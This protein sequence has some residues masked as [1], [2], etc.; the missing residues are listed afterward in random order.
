ML[1]ET[2]TAAP[3][4]AAQTRPATDI[5]RRMRPV[6][7]LFAACVGVFVLVPLLVIV[8]SSFNT[9]GFWQFPPTGVTLR[10]YR[11]LF[12]DPEFI[13]SFETSF[14]TAFAVTVMAAVLGV[15]AAVGITRGRKGPSNTLGTIALLPLLFP[16]VVLGVAILTLYLE[17]GARI[18]ILTLAL[19]QL[20]PA[21]PFAIRLMSVSLVG[22]SP[23]LERAAQNLGASPSRAFMRVVMPLTKGALLTAL[24]VV[25]VRVL[26]ETSIALFVSDADTVTVPV[27]LLIYRESEPGPLIAAGG[28]LLLVVSLIAAAVIIK[29]IGLGRAFGVSTGKG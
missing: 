23:N 10:W 6:A 4:A 22:I 17:L 28:T 8:T 1:N 2:V 15:L 13:R 29:T 3:P 5:P 9:V 16:H 24:L 21:L 11:Q 25:F 19:A 14:A 26:E 27:R 12:N 18:T 7:Y 20:I